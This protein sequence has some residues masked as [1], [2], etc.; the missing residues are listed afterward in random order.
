VPNESGNGLNNKRG[1]VGL[2]RTDS[3]HSGNC[4]FFVNLNDNEDL[5]PQPL[6]WGYAVFGKII[7]GM[8]VVDKIGHVP[9][10]AAGPFT[11]DAPVQQVV[12]LHAEYLNPPTTTPAPAPPA[13]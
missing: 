10:G 1:T 11:K 2:A 4:Q 3:P 7:E 13:Q 5:D 9:T 6:R 8:D 12:I